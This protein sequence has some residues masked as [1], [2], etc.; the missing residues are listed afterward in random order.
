MDDT[1]E[2]KKRIAEL[3]RMVAELRVNE[4]V[5]LTNPFV[6]GAGGTNGYVTVNVQGR[7]YKIMTT[8]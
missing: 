1:E 8:A 5:K 4:I 2:L 7:V 3:E 6:S